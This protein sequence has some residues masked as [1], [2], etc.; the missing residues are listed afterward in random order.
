M[1]PR[2]RIFS[3]V[4]E[5]TRSPEWSV[6]GTS[7]VP[8]GRRVVPEAVL[9]GEALEVGAVHARL[10][11]G[12]GDVAARARERGAHELELDRLDRLLLGDEELV[13]V[14]RRPPARALRAVEGGG[15]RELGREVVLARLGAAREEDEVLGDVLEL[16]HV[17]RE[18]IAEERALGRGGERG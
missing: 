17:P 2:P 4:K 9:L 3:I 12:A 13:V 1:P 14:A 6:L 7:V 5:P 15:P 8:G 10:A 11:R 18:R 16:A